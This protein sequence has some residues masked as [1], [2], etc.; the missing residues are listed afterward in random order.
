MGEAPVAISMPVTF[1]GD[2]YIS[3][4]IKASGGEDEGGQQKKK[5][6]KISN[7]LTSKQTTSTTHIDERTQSKRAKQTNARIQ[8]RTASYTHGING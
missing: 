7:V 2:M 1:I 6:K 8:E 5:W 3:A 4:E